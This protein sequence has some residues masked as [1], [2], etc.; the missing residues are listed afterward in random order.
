MTNPVILTVDILKQALPERRKQVEP[1]PDNAPSAGLLPVPI[2]RRKCSIMCAETAKS[3]V[4]CPSCG[5]VYL[6]SKLNIRSAAKCQQCK[7]KFALPTIAS[8]STKAKA[9][10]DAHVFISYSNKDA[11]VAELTLK[12]L[13]QQGVICWM[14]PRDIRP[15]SEWGGA[16]I[17]ALQNAEAMVLLFSENSNLSKQVLREVERAVAKAIPIIPVR[18]DKCEMSTSFEYFLSSMHWFDASKRPIDTRINELSPHLKAIINEPATGA[19]TTQFAV[20]PNSPL[21]GQHRIPRPLFLAVAVGVLIIVIGVCYWAFYASGDSISITGTPRQEIHQP[22]EPPKSNSADPSKLITLIQDT[23][24]PKGWT[25]EL[26]S[27]D[28]NAKASI[29]NLG[30]LLTINTT[31]VNHYRIL[32]LLN[33]LRRQQGMPELTLDVSN[34]TDVAKMAHT[35]LQTIINFDFI[36]EPMEDVI[37]YMQ[38]AID[39]R[40]TLDEDA[41]ESQSVSVFDAISTTV[42]GVPFQTALETMFAE[43][44]LTYFIR[45]DGLVI[46]TKKEASR[47]LTSRVY[48]VRDLATVE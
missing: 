43:Y 47:H 34:D 35:K 37:N 46:S 28:N 6:I 9:P 38:D 5:R 19:S 31:T 1:I 17:E 16:I 25:T 10:G 40:I 3:R 2:D 36:E 20:S 26:A 44:E 24:E 11:E 48:D 41:L 32:R 18:T 15:G 8:Q 30:G 7:T 12:T 27:S 21:T 4:S 23:V 22:V 29:A 42:Q 39:M 13:E 14:A 45:G 33:N